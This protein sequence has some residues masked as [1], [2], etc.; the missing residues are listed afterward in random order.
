MNR[1]YAICYEGD[2]KRMR[3]SQKDLYKNI[4]Q[5]VM[6]QSSG[7]RIPLL[8]SAVGREK[9]IKLLTFS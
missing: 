5:L 4:Y 2:K 8:I 1:I 7:P 9:M 6:G 3:E